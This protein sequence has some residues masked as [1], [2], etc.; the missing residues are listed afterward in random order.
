MFDFV[1]GRLQQRAGVIG[2][3]ANFGP[4]SLTFARH[5]DTVFQ[6][7]WSLEINKRA[8]TFY[9][10]SQL[11]TPQVLE[12]RPELDWTGNNAFQ[13]GR[14]A[15]SD[16]GYWLALTMGSAVRFYDVRA[17]AARP[18]EVF[19]SEFGQCGD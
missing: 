11:T 5:T 17:L 4:L 7:T 2:S 3:Y 10:T 18:D 14:L 8:L 1:G 6:S 13:L 9:P 19:A 12:L 15:L 16:D